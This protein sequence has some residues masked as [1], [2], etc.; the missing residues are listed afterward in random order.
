MRIVRIFG[1]ENLYLLNIGIIE[2][3]TRKELDHGHI[4]YFISKLLLGSIKESAV[5]FYD[6]GLSVAKTIVFCSQL[7][8][9]LGLKDT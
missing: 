1:K 4:R 5:D 7:G 3:L 6:L 2:V 8:N 9:C